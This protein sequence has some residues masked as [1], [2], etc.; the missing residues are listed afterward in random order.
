MRAVIKTAYLKGW[1][2]DSPLSRFYLPQRYKP[3]VCDQGSLTAALKI[4]ANGT[5]EV[6]VLS[7]KVALPYWHEQKK[8]G[9]TP[10]LAAMI[11]E[12][13]LC[14]HSEPVVFARSIIPLSLAGRGG[15]GLANLGQSPLGHLLFK[16]GRT[17][18]MQRDFIC[19][20]SEHRTERVTSNIY[21]RRTPYKYQG[22]TILVSEYFLPS[23]D[24]HL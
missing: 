21:G 15:N 9:R 12:V 10:H 1:H 6:Q 20:T 14:I 23:L 13:N 11:R 22:N 17:N 5:F 16:N 18:V 4:I 19:L 2:R 3:M 24:K 7:Q 8:L